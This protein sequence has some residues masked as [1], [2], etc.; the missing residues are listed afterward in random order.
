MAQAA[1]VLP[2]TPYTKRTEI[3][4]TESVDE[5]SKHEFFWGLGAYLDRNI[6]KEQSQIL[7]HIRGTFEPHFNSFFRGVFG[8]ELARVWS[9]QILAGFQLSDRT[10]KVSPLL[11][12]LYVNRI[13]GQKGLATLV[14]S[15][16]VGYEISVGIT[17]QLNVGLSSPILKVEVGY[18]HMLYDRAFLIRV[19]RSVF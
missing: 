3:T 16:T 17:E 11:Q 19:G 5:I 14:D 4:E 12:V 8:L 1:E 2:I 10:Q 9:T 15:S 7:G 13:E 6:Q 18:R